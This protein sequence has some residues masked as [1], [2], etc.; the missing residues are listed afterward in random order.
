MTII[1]FINRM[2]K[3]RDRLWISNSDIPMIFST[4][5]R[6]KKFRYEIVRNPYHFI[7]GHWPIQLY[8]AAKKKL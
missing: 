4:F 3:R 5:I 8:A 7:P 1:A 6:S 2:L